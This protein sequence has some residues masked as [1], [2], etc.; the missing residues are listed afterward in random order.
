MAVKRC[1]ARDWEAF[2]TRAHW[3]FW[4]LVDP[5]IDPDVVQEMVGEHDGWEN[6][7]LPDPAVLAR[8]PDLADGVYPLDPGDFPAG[9]EPDPDAPSALLER[10]VEVMPIERDGVLVR[11]AKARGLSCF[12]WRAVAHAATSCPWGKKLL[13]VRGRNV[14]V[15]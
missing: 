14:G 6:C 2:G 1:P 12:Y 8:W 4:R 5:A 7:F 11:M 9:F 10:V 15:G 13:T 3:Y